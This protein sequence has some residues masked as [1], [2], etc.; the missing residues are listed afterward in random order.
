MK[1]NIFALFIVL[2]FL[3]SVFTLFSCENKEETSFT[4]YRTVTENKITTEYVL[5]V[6]EKSGTF[7]IACA[8][9]PDEEYS[10]TFVYKNGYIV[11]TSQK[12]GEEYVATEGD[13]F[14]YVVPQKEDDHTHDFVLKNEKSG[15]CVTKGLKTYTCSICGQTKEESTSLGDHSYQLISHTVATC[16]VKEKSVYR[17]QYCNDEKTN[18]GDYDANNHSWSEENRDSTGCQNKVVITRRCVWCNQVETNRILDEYGAHNYDENGV[19]TYC[20]YDSTGL[21]HVHTDEDED[22]VCDDCLISFSVAESL[23]SNGYAIE[24][25]ILY[26]GAYPSSLSDLSAEE[27]SKNGKKDPYTGYYRYNGASYLLQEK[28]SQTNVY[29]VS[30]LQW[31]LL[32]ENDSSYTYVCTTVVDAGYY[33]SPA[34][35]ISE[36]IWV[37]QD[38]VYK[39]VTAYYHEKTDENGE[40]IEANSFAQSDV[41]SFLNDTFLTAFTTKERTI[42]T[43]DP[44]ILPDKIY[45]DTVNDVTFSDYARSRAYISSYFTLTPGEQTNTVFCSGYPKSSEKDITAILGF[46]PVITIRFP[47]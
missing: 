44:I 21:C 14:S 11:L 35:I 36:S 8:T 18:D 45:A 7:S 5:T 9:N 46:V 1:K 34:K 22:G 42:L 37:E 27:I 39:K 13:T 38:K 19:C 41:F 33:L 31:K 26:F 2:V 32:R 47:S 4:Y 20:H 24:N 30:P 15:T 10:G 3:L 6:D 28:G 17:C 16:S 40:K 43:A 23:S 12:K 29:L 25:N